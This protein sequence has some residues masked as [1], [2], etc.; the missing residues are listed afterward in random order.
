MDTAFSQLPMADALP[1]LR[2]ALC[3]RPNAIVVAPPGAGKT[4]L[5]PPALLDIPWA[6]GREG[7]GRILMLEPRRLAARAAA[8]RMAALRGEAVG[9]VVGYRTRVD[10]AI[11]AATRIEV[12]T[13]GL[14]LRRLLADPGLA[15]VAAVILDEV[16][17]RSLEA[18]LALA[19]L[20][21]LQILLRPDLR[22]I[23]MS[24]TAES[25]RLAAHLDAA[26]ITCAARPHPVEIS[27]A[28][29]D[30]VG[31]RDLPEAMAR[32]IRGALAIGDA[33]GDATGDATGGDILA[34]L[35]GM[36]EI[37]RVMALLEGCAATVLALHGD[38]SP[39][40]QDRALSIAA[41]R[42]VVL[43]SAIAETSLTVPGVR[44]VIDGGFRRVPEL[45]P[46]TGLT[47]LVTRRI[48]RAS[49]TQRAGRAGR[50][51]PGRAIRLWTAALERGLAPTDAPE[52]LNAELSSLLITCAAWG[53]APEALPFLDP[54]PA[55]S[56]A[57]SAALLR[58][59]GAL[60]SANRLTPAGR[61]MA[62][63]GAEPR[64]AAMML[65]A[66]TTMEKALAADLAA[67]LEERDPLRGANAPADI[68]LRLG[69]LSR[70]SGERG[71]VIARLRQTAR[72]Y[73]RRLGAADDEKD[74]PMDREAD[75]EAG[76][77]T[78]G[79]L[80]A[81]AF[82]DRIAARR[83]EPGSFRLSGGGG[84]RLPAG[85]PLARAPLLVVASLEAKGASLIRLAA[86]L[87]P[88]RLPPA[89]AA[90]VTE[91]IDTSLDPATGEVFARRRR[92]LGALI[93]EDRTLPAALDARA[94]GLGAW[95]TADPARLPWR[96]RARQTQARIGCLARLAGR[97]SGAA[98]WPESDDAA[99]A[100]RLAA[101]LAD[102]RVTLERAADLGDFDLAE[103]LLAGLTASQRAELGRELPEH[104]DLPGGRAAI[105]YTGET[106]LASARAQVFFGLGATPKLA[107]G[108]LPLRIALLSPAGRPV[109]ITGD[110]AGFWRS[111]WAEVRRD[112]RGRYPRHPWP[113]N[114]A[115]TP[116]APR[117]GHNKPI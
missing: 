71:G 49:A 95:I 62:E 5:V 50:E 108:R 44:V 14:L 45:D 111:G 27:H 11:S 67:I 59:L 82:P 8:R 98:P 3:L 38:L 115:T 83:G 43:A 19:L 100:R 64:L 6:A 79:R 103:F 74:A 41:G 57:A 60:D 104:I 69:L 48:S 65:A 47:R 36:A 112:M 76:R 105:D 28:G 96:D 117:T 34:F 16:H 35:P 101:A 15:G 56:L 4:T 88:A 66:E 85:D 113:E 110:L 78:L 106:P 33:I 7:G 25:D 68:G 37:R 55:A 94:A 70:G 73:R 53:T 52:I 75:H 1:A 22:L 58:D 114:P 2:T 93:L 109:A 116:P 107:G 84:A 17:E 72:Q 54:P 63:L 21:D 87:D 80:L 40:E 23:A 89:L 92:R 86:P 61:R 31:P 20:R 90:R 42:R 51:G 46:G 26:V 24:A 32:A 102:G 81:A 29:R 12:I 9:G 10:A 39:A 77:E 30:L 97:D 13:E 91:T 18:D 99:I